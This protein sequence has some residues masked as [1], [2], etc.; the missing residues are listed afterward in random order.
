MEKILHIIPAAGKA[1]RIGG[2]PK[3][4][5]PISQ[6]NFLINFHSN[7]LPNDDQSI[8]KVIAVS[9]EFYETVHRLNLNTEILEVNTNTMNETILKVINSY[10]S[11]S[12]YLLTMPDT[13]YLDNNVIQRLRFNFHEKKSNVQLALW[14]IKKNQIGNLGQVEIK[15]KKIIQIVD[16]DPDCNF[17]Y[18]WGAIIWNKNVNNF[19]NTNEST[20]GNILNPLLSIAE[21]IEYVIAENEYFDCGTF[22]EY[23][24]LL[25]LIGGK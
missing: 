14:K 18:A 4:L 1:S 8:K 20:I 3:F 13:Y 22:Y 25:K 7:L 6:N 17:P 19:I 9:S 21:E 5:L 2:I 15:N 23:T 24:K 16:K 11:Y 12:N 10:P